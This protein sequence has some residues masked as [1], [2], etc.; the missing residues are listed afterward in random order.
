MGRNPN[1]AH[2]TP[3]FHEAQ[4]TIGKYRDIADTP[5]IIII[6]RN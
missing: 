4:A 2:A 1:G 5:I 3:A 6:K